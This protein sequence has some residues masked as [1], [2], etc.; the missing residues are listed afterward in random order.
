MTQL[1][2]DLFCWWLII[3]NKMSSI[4]SKLL[5]IFICFFSLTSQGQK[6]E[7]P[8]VCSGKV[9]RL[10]S[11]PSKFISSRNIDIWLPKNYSPQ[12]KYA[13]LYMH[14]GQM[15]FDANKTWNKQ[16]W[17]VD[18]TLTKLFANKDI[19]KCIVVGIWNTPNRHSE[20]F[21]QKPFNSL[22]KAYKDSLLN[23]ALKYGNQKLFSKRVCSD[24]YLKF[25]VTELKPYI[26]KHYNVKKD[27]S[28]TFIGGSSMGGLISMYALFEY[29]SVFGGV[30]CMSTH[31]LGTHQIKNNPI[32][33]A[34]ANYIEKNIRKLNT[35]KLYFDYDTE[36]LDQ[37]YEP[38]QK[39]INKV[40]KDKKY[41]HFKSKKFKGHNHSENSWKMR[42]AIPFKFLLKK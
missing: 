26:D 25:I 27:S 20:Y 35:H 42:L 37:I 17:G 13:V 12:Q 30:I 15:L 34:F 14:D 8:I 29:P 1:P 28:N 11:F 31:W 19:K 10:V 33:I 24:N 6:S 41:K 4:K 40:L 9:D 5:L 2:I 22:P 16:E 23:K 38:Y 18:E 32:P 36:T 3:F 21:P 7:S 39:M